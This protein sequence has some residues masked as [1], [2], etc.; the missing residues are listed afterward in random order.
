MPDYSTTQKVSR[1]WTEGVDKLTNTLLQYLQI[2]NMMNQQ[3]FQQQQQQRQLAQEQA[4]PEAARQM[5][6]MA[7]IGQPSQPIASAGGLV[8]REQPSID[9]NALIKSPMGQQFIQQMALAKAKQQPKEF[10]IPGDVDSF[11]AAHFPYDTTEK[12]MSALNEFRKPETIE[13]FKEWKK[14]TAL[15]FYNVIPTSEGFVPFNA[16]TG[17]PEGYSGYKKPLTNEMITAN[18][19][20]GTLKETLSK[21]KEDY[22]PDF[23]GPISGRI[24]STKEATIGIPEKQASFYANLEQ[25]KNS[26]IYLLSGKQINEG[27]YNRLLKQL[28]DRNLPSNVFKVRMRE[29]DRTLDSIIKEREAGSGG[30]GIPSRQPAAMAGGEA[31]PTGKTVV[32]TGKEKGTG[33]KVIMYSDGSVEYAK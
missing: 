20:I 3:N 14:S 6:T 28:P 22:D 16:R 19:Q 10:N 29:F 2:K 31:A 33:N 11:L 8:T 25:T 30:Y 9:I 24:G 4:A 26:L 15:P 18:Q 7:G 1:P 13:A 32:R 23:V 21:V 12:R 5:A 27:E 17:K